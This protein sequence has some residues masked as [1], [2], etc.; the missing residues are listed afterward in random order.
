MM[1]GIEWK[2]QEAIL[3]SMA[4]SS[5]ESRIRGTERERLTWVPVE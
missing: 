1:N 2:S 3:K 4:K 5:Q